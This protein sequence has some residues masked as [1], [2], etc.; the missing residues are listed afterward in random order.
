MR[1]LIACFLTLLT[2]ASSKGQEVEFGLPFSKYYSSQDYNGGIQN[3]GFA[4]NESGLIYVANNFGMLEYDGTKW[5]R[6]SLPNSTKIRDIV[7]D[8]E[9]RIFAS[10]QG[11]FGFFAPNRNGY[12]TFTSLLDKLPENERNLEEVWKIFR[13]HNSII[14]CTFNR[15]FVFSKNLELEYVIQSNSYF[16]GFFSSNNQM[17]VQE[18]GLGLKKLQNQ[19]LEL[20]GNPKSFSNSYITGLVSTGTED[21]LI[22]TRDQGIFILKDAEAKVWSPKGLPSI[23]NISHVLRLKDGKIAIGTQNDG[24]YVIN[25]NGQLYFHMDKSRGLQN[26]SVLSQFEDING[27]LWIGHN[28]GVSLLELSLPFRQVDRFSNLSGTGYDAKVKDNFVYFGTNNGVSYQPLD[29]SQTPSFIDGT[30]GQVYQINSIQ[31]HLLVAHNDG[32]FEIAGNK[33]VQLT[34]YQGV[35]NF[36][37]LKKSPNHIISGTY[38]GLILFEIK[39][40]KVEFLRKLEGFDESSRIIQQDDEG[41]IWMTHGYKGVYKLKL[42]DDLTSVSSTF[43]GVEQGLP[44][45][46]L[47]SVWNINDRLLFTTEYGIYTY[48][49]SKDRF[50]RD[51]FFRPYFGD[52]FLITSLLEDP[53]GNI[54]YIGE[55]EVG[56]LE[57]QINGTYLKNHQIFNKVIPYLNDDLQNISLIRGN[58]ALFAANDG[59]IW[60]KLERN[61]QLFSSAF[62]TLIRS[63]FQTGSSDSLIF[64]RNHLQVSHSPI[65]LPYENA[66]LRFEVTHPTPNQESDVMFQFWLQGFEEGFGEWTTKRD[67]AYTNLREGKYTFHVKSRDLFGNEG[68]QDSFDFEVLPPWYRSIA[69]YF[70]YFVLSVIALFYTYKS[71]EK[72]YQKKTKRITAEQRRKLEEKESDLQQSQKEIERLQTE[73]LES[74]IKSKNKELASATMHLI[75]KNG[76]IDHTKTHLTSIIKKSKNQEVKSELNKVIQS[77]EKNIKGD[78]EWEQFEIHFDQVHGDF[79]SR[80]KKAYPD[81]SPQ[82]IKLSAYLRMNL[83]SKEIAYLMNISTRGIEIA[84]YRL[85]KKIQLERQD[86]LQE[87]ILKF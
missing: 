9:N 47:I 50:E 39:N 35:W 85:R 49:S 7:I 19:S 21:K 18:K 24:V 43:Y 69:A 82:E 33:S 12:L 61:I 34:D 4:Q 74:E 86:N 64:T 83:S 23:K 15:L 52:E 5:N 62:P 57:K 84:R 2:F 56:V 1:N 70:I 81:L 78:K 55:Q 26:N 30:D 44:T 20:L 42:S 11:E 75:N 73:K 37:P 28:N 63:V 53:L 77:I 25:E 51:E 54:F 72:R 8:E 27:N 38:T 14:F 6:Y 22:F 10:G 58:E 48:N 68:K 79:M 80:F 67:K 76:F 31:N 60:F 13:L 71:V 59:F 66:D 32:A 41:H 45:N 29:K 16:E 17:I 3:Y 40:G 46:L 65:K 87:F 36:Q